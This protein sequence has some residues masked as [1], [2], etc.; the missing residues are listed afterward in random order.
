[1]IKIIFIFL[2]TLMSK[3]FLTK[4]KKMEVI[5]FSKQRIFLIENLKDMNI[6]KQDLMEVKYKIFI[7]IDS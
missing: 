7:T 3:E 5:L 6:S 1:M 2:K 4:H